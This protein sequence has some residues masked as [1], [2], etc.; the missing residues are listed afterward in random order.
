MNVVSV[1]VKLAAV[2]KGDSSCVLFL[3]VQRAQCSPVVGGDFF[4]VSSTISHGE[5]VKSSACRLPALIS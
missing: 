5:L 1:V 4:S 2:K 3:R